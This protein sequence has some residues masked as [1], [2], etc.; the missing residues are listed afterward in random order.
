VIAS[1]SKSQ[2]PFAFGGGA[3][4][5]LTEHW[6]GKA[7]YLYFEKGGS[8]SRWRWGGLRSAYFV[9]INNLGVDY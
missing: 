1:A 4:Y 9:Y 6:I 3:E 7:E 2:T 5:P 8:Y